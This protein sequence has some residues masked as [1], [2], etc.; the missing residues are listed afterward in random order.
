MNT[1]QDV[2]AYILALMLGATAPQASV[3]PGATT[4]APT[5][6]PAQTAIVT[7][8]PS[9]TAQ[10]V[11]ATATPQPTATPK[12]S[13]APEPTA[14]AKSTATPKPTQTPKPTATPKPTPTPV[15]T[16]IVE[17]IERV[18]WRGLEGK[19]VKLMQERLIELGYMEGPAVLRFGA[20][21]EAGVRQFQKD[22]NL[23]VD[24]VAGAETLLRM[25]SDEVIF[26]PA[27]QAEALAATATPA[28]T[29][30]AQATGT[31]KSTATPQAT[32]T[33]EAPP[34]AE[35]A[36]PSV[37]DDTALEVTL[38]PPETATQTPVPGPAPITLF[39]NMP[40]TLEGQMAVI[41]VGQD[42]AGQWMLPLPALAGALGLACERNENAYKMTRL[43]ADGKKLKEYVV[44][45]L[46]TADGQPGAIMVL[47]DTEAVVPDTPM[48]IILFNDTLF[49]PTEFVRLVFGFA[50]QIDE[51]GIHLNTPT[52]VP[53][54]TDVPTEPPTTELPPA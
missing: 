6:A 39:P 47:N 1:M 40:V 22:Q 21:T 35:Q 46:P 37:A 8:A 53:A 18:L 32:A 13:V 29:A 26:A 7:I 14:T 36:T 16:P 10:V 49:V 28:P 2:L 4:N 48:K 9:P 23:T 3:A 27:E 33:P 15:P 25:F 34:T 45:W 12:P 17:G 52:P 54:P 30:A 20:K 31:P 41:P 11:V 43:D 24:G 51:G 19:D 44:G 38:P 42:S 50:V 5:T